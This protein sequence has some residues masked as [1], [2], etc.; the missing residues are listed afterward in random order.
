MEKIRGHKLL[1]ALV[2]PVF[3]Q[4]FFGSPSDI[5]DGEKVQVVNVKEEFSA[6]VLKIM[7]EFIDESKG[8]SMK[9]E[10]RKENTENLFMLLNISYRYLLPGIFLLHFLN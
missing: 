8:K 3:K 6:D 4:E 1:L 9:A 5:V 7:I 10:L 2:S